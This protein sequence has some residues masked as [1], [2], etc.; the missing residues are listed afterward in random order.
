MNLVFENISKVFQDTVALEKIYFTTLLSFCRE[1]AHIEEASVIESNATDAKTYQLMMIDD[2]V[3]HAQET[4]YIKSYQQLLSSEV[5]SLF[6][7]EET[8]HS[9]LL[10]MLQ[11]EFSVQ[12]KGR[13][14]CSIEN[15]L[16][17]E[18]IPN[19]IPC[20]T[21]QEK[22]FI[23][24]LFKDYQKMLQTQGAFDVDDVTMEAI[25]H[26]SAPI[27]RRNRQVEGYDY[28]NMQAHDYGTEFYYLLC[29][30]HSCE[31]AEVLLFPG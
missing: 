4:N 19:G 11:H 9:T 15:Y 25:S 7:K 3:N 29:D 31:L 13:T 24:S 17:L 10:N 8:D 30:R 2:V 16:E 6:D 5:Y 27:W 21:K 26:L 12:I 23:F 1:F 18:P 20:K 28:K 14:D 22:E